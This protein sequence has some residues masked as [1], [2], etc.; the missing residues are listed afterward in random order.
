MCGSELARV[1]LFPRREGLTLKDGRVIARMN[2]VLIRQ[3]GHTE[4]RR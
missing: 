1:A 4:V 2:T 3:T